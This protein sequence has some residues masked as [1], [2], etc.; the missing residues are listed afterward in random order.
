MEKK[1]IS[2][3]FNN[4]RGYNVYKYLLKKKEYKIDI[5]LCKKNLNKSLFSK[6]NKFKLIKIFDNSFIK[7]FKKKNYFL[8]ISAGWP[9]KFP[10]ELI[11]S[12]I[13]GTINLHAGKLPEYRGGSPL[14]WQI[15]EGKKK[16]F[17]SIIKMTKNFDRGPIYLQKSFNLSPSEDIKDAHKKVNKAYPLMTYKVI[18][19]IIKNVKPI[20][21]SSKNARYM[22]QRKDYDGKIDWKTMNANDVFN[23]VRAISKPYPGAFYTYKKKKFRI[24]KC[25]KLK[26]NKNLKSGEILYRNNKKVIKCKRNAIEIIKEIKSN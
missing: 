5:Y 23:L 19:K 2:I 9:L 4:L 11:N 16:I 8:N 18:Q 22:Y 3:F 12:S 1:Y 21:Q 6:L 20:K 26:F 15:I 13:K 14:N 7:N 25:K 24:F 17:V 10:S